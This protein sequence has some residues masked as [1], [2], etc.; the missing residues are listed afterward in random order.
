MK[1]TFKMILKIRTDRKIFCVLGKEDY[2]NLQQSFKFSLIYAFNMI[3]I[4]TSLRKSTH[5]NYQSKTRNF[6]FLVFDMKEMLL[7]W[8]CLGKQRTKVNQEYV[9]KQKENINK[10]IEIMKMNQAKILQL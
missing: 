8:I 10:K 2:T 3:S 5:W 4:K 6:G 9:Y 7:S 1:K